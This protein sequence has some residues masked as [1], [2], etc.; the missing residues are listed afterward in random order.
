MLPK[1]L[2]RLIPPEHGAWG[3]L[4]LAVA[5]GMGLAPTVAGVL[6]VLGMIVGVIARH[7]AH[8]AL[9]GVRLWPVALILAAIAAS[10]WG[11]ALWWAPDAWPWLAGAT[12][13]AVLQ[14]ICTVG[15]QRH[16]TAS[17]LVGGVALALVG[18]GIVATKP[19]TAPEILVG[20]I[21]C[22]LIAIT[23]LVRARRQPNSRWAKHALAGHLAA[24]AGAIAAHFIHSAPLLLVG[25]FIVLTGRCLRLTRAIQ[26]PVT[27]KVIGLAEIPFLALLVLAIVLGVRM[28]W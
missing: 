16:D 8:L 22:Y 21:I 1:K 9:S 28:D 3:F 23:P 12:C 10:A 24:L 14:V 6:I 4:A 15:S 19:L 11:L 2:R 7:A 25:Y 20:A 17:V 5:G 13:L 26:Q 27:P 18:G